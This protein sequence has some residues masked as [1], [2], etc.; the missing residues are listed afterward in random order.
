[1]FKNYKINLLEYFKDSRI[2]WSV[3]FNSPH[4]VELKIE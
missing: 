1:M 3:P 2:R 4:P